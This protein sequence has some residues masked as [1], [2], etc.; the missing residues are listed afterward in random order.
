MTTALKRTPLYARHVELG[1]KMVP[2]AG[3]EL[4]VQY[5]AGII[6]EHH[7]V[8]QAAGLFDVSHMGEVI[9]QGAEALALLQSLTCNDISVLENGRAQYNAL[10]TPQGGVVDDIIVYRQNA[11]RFF[12]CVNASNTERDF[13]W[14]V[15]HNETSAGVENVSAR[16]GQ[17]ALQGP[18]AEEIMRRLSGGEEVANLAYF[19]FIETT[20]CGISGV[21]AA[22]T[23][24]TGEDGFELFVPV[25][26]TARLWDGVLESGAPLGLIP[27]GLGA[28]DSLRLEAAYPLHGHELSEEISAIE[29]GLGWVVK[30]DKGEF[31]GRERLAREKREGAA[32]ALVGFFVQ[33]AGIARHGA[34][35]RAPS[36]EIIGQ[37]TS[38][39]K[40][41]TVNRALGLALV[42][43]RFSAL[44]SK[45]VIEVR[46]E[47]LE[48]EVVKK[49][50]Y[51]RPA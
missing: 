7:A 3:W 20:L 49:P 26:S 36:G 50:F 45:I 17:I 35:V 38:G 28:R 15:T 13:Q 27:A 39:T 46:G 6:A 37:V 29:S 11:E 33:G 44:G 51:K 30:P 8:R 12:V 14:I 31:L 18:R 4:P 24:Y 42:D 40:T 9:V 43:R 48:A 5:K 32:R 34:V 41:P 22:R 47:P 23:G 1:G 2:F 19:S 21:V 10:T 25:D 16:Y